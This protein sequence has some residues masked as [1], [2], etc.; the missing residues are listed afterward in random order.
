MSPVTVFGLLRNE[1]R[2]RL[3][4]YLSEHRRAELADVAEYIAAREAGVSRESISRDD[5]KRVFISLYQTHVPRLADHSVV[6][7][8]S[9]TG[10]VELVGEERLLGPFDRT[11]DRRPW[12]AYYGAVAV[13]GWLVAVAL[14]ASGT[15]TLPITVGAL[16]VVPLAL[17]AVA[18]VHW[19]ADTDDAPTSLR[20]VIDEAITEPD[21]TET[22]EESNGD[23]SD[24]DGGDAAS[25][26]TDGTDTDSDAT[27]EAT[28]G[29]SSRTDAAGGS[30]PDDESG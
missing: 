24:A 4:L 21:E 3:L 15:A 30:P 23:T 7:Y 12:P 5:R 13:V 6:A 22:T 9:D 8:D 18:V 20:D 19:Q 1:R 2:L 14:I 26:T 28:A 17:S 25:G 10:V 27:S 16:V 29:E 11:T